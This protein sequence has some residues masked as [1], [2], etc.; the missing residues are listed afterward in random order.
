MK[1]TIFSGLLL[2][3][4]LTASPMSNAPALAEGRDTAQRQV[5]AALSSAGS[6]CARVSEA[7]TDNASGPV[8][9]SAGPAAR[10]MKIM[11]A[12]TC[13]SNQWCCRHEDFSKGTC[14]KCCPK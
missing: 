6:S 2:A 14:A 12:V 10:G 13:G 5:L 9:R 7:A 11:A 3:I 1:K 8:C 4:A